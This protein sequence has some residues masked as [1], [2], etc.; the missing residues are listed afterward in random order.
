MANVVTIDAYRWIYWLR[1][2]GVVQ[3]SAATWHC[4]LHWSDEPGE[5]SQ[6]LLLL[7]STMAARLGESVA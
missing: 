3:R 7:S 5:L 4:V 2:I 6:W 1:L